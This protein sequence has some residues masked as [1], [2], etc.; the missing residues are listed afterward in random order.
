MDAAQPE[1]ILLQ[2]PAYLGRILTRALHA[3]TLVFL[4]GTTQRDA[5]RKFEGCLVLY[6]IKYTGERKL[7]RTPILLDDLD[8]DVNLSPRI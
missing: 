2:A 8:I 5:L 4:R 3:R 1:F 6:Q 7:G